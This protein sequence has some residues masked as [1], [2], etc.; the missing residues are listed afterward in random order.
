MN[1]LYI[2]YIKKKFFFTIFEYFLY[3]NLNISL[4][5]CLNVNTLLWTCSKPL[6][7]FIIEVEKPLFL[8]ITFAIKP[9]GQRLVS[10]FFREVCNFLGGY[11]DLTRIYYATYSR[12]TIEL[13]PPNLK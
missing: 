8:P 10:V 3:D 4:V 11:L 2:N 13:Y 1:L 9:P 7:K 6:S 5:N 12:S